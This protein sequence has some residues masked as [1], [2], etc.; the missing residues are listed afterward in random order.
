MGC[1]RVVL[2]LMLARFRAPSALRYRH[3]GKKGG[4]KTRDAEEFLRQREY[5]EALLPE[6]AG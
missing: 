2:Q 1:I 3:F 6:R 5:I 4:G